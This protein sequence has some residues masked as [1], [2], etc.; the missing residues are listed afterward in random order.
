M[1]LKFPSAVAELNLIAILSLL[2][3]GSG[4]RAALHAAN[5]RGAY[6]NIRA[7]VLS[8][9][10]TSS[11]EPGPSNLLSAQGMTKITR[12]QIAGLMNVSLHVEAPHPTMPAVTIGQLGGPLLEFVELITSTLQSTG[13][14]LVNNGYPDLGSFVMEALEDAKRA[15]IKKGLPPIAELVV[16]K[17]VRAF[18]AFRDMAEVNGQPVYI[19]KKALF[20]VHAIALRFQPSSTDADPSTATSIPIP[21]TTSLPIFSDNVIPS[22]LVH[23]GILDL[24]SVAF[25][26]LASAFPDP[27]LIVPTLLS[28][29][30]SDSK[31]SVKFEPPEDGPQLSVEE[32]YVLRAAAINACEIIVAAA[33]EIEVPDDKEKERWLRS[34]TLPEIDGW[35]WAVAKDRPDYRKLSRYVTKPTI[36]F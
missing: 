10:L 29:A 4:Y 30:R 13:N 6:D 31:T 18:P 36:F 32:S 20:L 25:A 16:E 12:E 26:K 28:A 24:S 17:T 23:F 22:M 34:I 27:K 5:G 8:L 1:P 19:F 3:F 2:N 14:I 15:G 7:L 11:E 35:L 21:D 33:K 9:Y